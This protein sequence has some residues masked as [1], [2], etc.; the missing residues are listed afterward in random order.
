[1][2][3]TGVKKIIFS[4]EEIKK[5]VEELGRQISTDY[6]ALNPV[7]ISV[8]KGTLY[9]SADLTRHMD[10]QINM[11]FISLGLYHG[12]DKSTGI[13]GID[14]DLD[15]NISGRHVILV[16]SIV[17]TG[18]TLGYLIQNLESRKPAS[19]KI[20]TLLNDHERRLVNIPIEYSGFNVSDEFLVGYGL[21][22]KQKFRHLPY[23]AE[24][25]EIEYEE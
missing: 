14:R 20:C 7:I 13:V 2:N 3:L 4:Q 19:I 23:I 9:F 25:D 21:D 12:I 11:D 10:C 24:F 6:K 8:L 5:R 22:Y 16:E 15:I 17:R 18:L 1:M